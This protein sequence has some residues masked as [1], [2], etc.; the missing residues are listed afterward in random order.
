M[1]TNEHL[2]LALHRLTHKN[3]L[4]DAVVLFFARYFIFF[5]VLDFFAVLFFWQR[6]AFRLAS[7]EFIIAALIAFFANILIG[8]FYR[9]ERPCERADVHALFKPFQHWK[10]FPSDHTTIIFVCA[11]VT[12][13][14]GMPWISLA[15]IG[16]GLLVGAARVVAGVHY[17]ADVAGGAL[18]GWFAG[19][20]VGMLGQWLT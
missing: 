18:W 9:T 4:F 11:G 12:A 2:L 7:F 3:R 17:P 5:V 14:F 19:V 20:V 15:Y 6:A 10:T 13:L 8:F 16:C 1:N